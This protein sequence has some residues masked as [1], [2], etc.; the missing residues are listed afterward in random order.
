[1]SAFKLLTLNYTI[2]VSNAAL[3]S[4][5]FECSPNILEDGHL[6]FLTNNSASQF[7][8]TFVFLNAEMMSM[9]SQNPPLKEVGTTTPKH[10]HPTI[11]ESDVGTLN[12]SHGRGGNREMLSIAVKIQANHETHHVKVSK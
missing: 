2:A 11:Y 1:M 10:M 7:P 12:V 9:P 4:F 5:L 6:R 3:S 8:L